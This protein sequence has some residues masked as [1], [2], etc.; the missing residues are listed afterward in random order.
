MGEPASFILENHHLPCFEEHT[1]DGVTATS[2]TDS[3]Y[4]YACE[5]SHKPWRH[6]YAL[7]SYM[8]VMRHIAIGTS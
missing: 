7:V 1:S 2:R 5:F 3:T 6:R 8:M 4:G